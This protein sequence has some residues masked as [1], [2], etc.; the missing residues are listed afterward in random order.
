MDGSFI[1]S[2]D[3]F[4][5]TTAIIKWMIKWENLIV[6]CS[7]SFP[8]TYLSLKI[9]FLKKLCELLASVSK[10]SLKKLCELMRSVRFRNPYYCPTEVARSISMQKYISVARFELLAIN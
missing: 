8:K 10:I 5:S 9:S 1:V 4:G 2:C 3:L 6:F 7:A